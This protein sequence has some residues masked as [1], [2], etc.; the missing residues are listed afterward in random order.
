MGYAKILKI[1]FPII[2]LIVFLRVDKSLGL[3]LLSICLI[4]LLI[5]C[6]SVIT[7]IIANRKYSAG[8]IDEST[9]L[10]ELAYKVPFASIKLRTSCAYMLMRIGKFKRAEEMLRNLNAEDKSESENI[11]VKLN[12]SIALWKNRSLDEAI[13]LLEG[14]YKKYKT[15]ILYEDLGYYY[16]LKGDYEKA[17]KFNLEAYEYASDDGIILDNLGQTYYCLND[18]GKAFD[19]YDRLIEMNPSFVS[20]YYNYGNVLLKLDKKEE[21]LAS[22]K[23]CLKY[24]FSALSQVSKE[25]VEKKISELESEKT[26]Q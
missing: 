10:F 19:I 21:A 13:K 2:S 7:I 6:V 1:V 17:L 11:S 4:Y 16:I 18:Y 3:I 26:E 12:L 24:K 15:T 8:K 20:V 5:K 23:N 25:Q 14:L 22:F 9:K